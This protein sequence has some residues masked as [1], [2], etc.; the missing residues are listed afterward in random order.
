M[1]AVRT[2]I[3]RLQRVNL[4]NASHGCD[5]RRPDRAARADE[6]SVRIALVHETLRHQIQRRKAVADDRLELFIQPR[7]HRL[8]Q[9]IAIDFVRFAQ[10]HFTEDVARVF[11]GRRV[12]A[13]WK[14]LE[15]FA[16]VR[17]FVWYVN[18]DAARGLF[19]KIAKL[20]QHLRRRFKIERRLKRCVLK[21]IFRQ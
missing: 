15:L 16:T 17:N 19:A 1:F 12:R 4:R 18:N 8:R 13:V 3:V 7:L 5:K 20:F 11:N 21:A 6:V 9:R 10:R 2:D 14:R